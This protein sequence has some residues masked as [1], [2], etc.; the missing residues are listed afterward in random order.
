MAKR[1]LITQLPAVHQTDML[2]RFFGA[3]VDQVF[4][5]GRADPI[6]GYIGQRPA[7]TDTTKDFYVA[8]PDKNRA[9][10]QLEPTMVG[11]ENGAITRA[12]TYD[13]LLGYLATLGV[14]TTD[15]RRLFETD[16]YAW[17]PP[18]DI[19]KL[20]NPRQ[21]F[22]FGDVE[23]R[24]SLPV[25]PLTAP[26]AAAVANGIT[27]NFPLPSP[28]VGV[29]SDRNNPAV[30]VDGIQIEV[31]TFTDTHVTVRDVPPNGSILTIFRYAS[32]TEALTGLVTLGSAAL[33]GLSKIAP[34]AQ[35]NGTRTRFPLRAPL[36]T[37]PSPET[38]IA[39][40]NGIQ[41]S[42][43]DVLTAVVS[44]TNFLNGLSATSGIVDGSFIFDGSG[45][46]SALNFAVGDYVVPSGLTGAAAVNNGIEFR[47]TRLTGNTMVVSPAPDA[48]ATQITGWSLRSNA[49]VLAEAPPADIEVLAV[50]HAPFAPHVSRRMTQQRPALTSNMAV[51]VYDARNFFNGWDRAVLDGDTAYGGDTDD[52]F[53][54]EGVGISMR[55]VSFRDMLFGDTGAY[56]VVDRS[57]K[58]RNP[59]SVRNF[60]VHGDSFRWSGQTFP[61]RQAARPII[62]F[63]RDI[64]LWRYGS[65]RLDPA[66]AI[67]T[68]PGA[69]VLPL[70][71]F[72]TSRAIF[73]QSAW[74]DDTTTTVSVP[75]INGQIVGSVAVDGGRVLLEGQRLLVAQ[76]NPM[77]PSFNNSIYRVHVTEDVIDGYLENVYVLI[78]ESIQ[79]EADDILSIDLVEYLPFDADAYDTTYFDATER[80]V[81]FYFDGSRWERA[82][83]WLRR[84]DPL[85][86]L[87]DANGVALDNEAV[88][89]STTFVGNRLFGYATGSISDGV[90]DRSV[91][92][93][94]NNSLVFEVDSITQSIS[95]SNGEFTGTRFHA[96]REDGEDMLASNWHVRAKP[97]EQAF[98]SDGSYDVPV[99]L[100]ANPDNEEVTFIS[101]SGFF[102]H[103]GSLLAQQT[104]FV[105]ETYNN[106]NW[107]DLSR[108]LG[109]GQHILQH[110]A[111]LLRTML[112]ASDLRFDLPE[113][114]RYC[115][116]EYI[117]FRAKFLNRV[118]DLRD[119]HLV[120][121]ATN[122]TDM[123]LAG[124]SSVKTDRMPDG[125][126]AQSQMAVSGSFIPTTP[127][128]LGV[129]PLWMPKNTGNAIRGHDGSFVPLHGDYRDNALLGLELL[130]YNSI[131][132]IIR[133]SIRP[134]FDIDLYIDGGF[135]FSGNTGYSRSAF[136]KLL[137]PHFRRWCLVNGIDGV[138]NEG[139]L[140]A[141]PFTWNYRGISNWLGDALPGNWRAIYRWLFGTITPNETPWEMLGFNTRPVWWNEE[142]G[143]AP[144]TRG[145][146]T[147]WTD[148]EQGRIAQGPLAGIH[149]RY[150][151]IGML[152]VLPV[153]D[154][155]ALLDPVAAQIVRTPVTYQMA[156]RPWEPG[157]GGPVEEQWRATSEYGFSL[158]QIGFAMKPARFVEQ[159]WDVAHQGLVRGQWMN[160]TLNR[161]PRNSELLV[162]REQDANGDVV[163]IWGVQQWIVDMLASR[164]EAASLFG[165]AVRG[166]DA[167]LTHK[168][169]G[170]TSRDGLRV[171]TDS[172]G[173]V[174]DEDINIELYQSPSLRNEVYSGVIIERTERGWRVAG[175]DA[176]TPSFSI[177]PG[178]ENGP[179][180]YLGDTAQQQ[181][182][183]LWRAGV[184]YLTG[185]LVAYRES[186][187]RCNRSHT[188]ASTF[189]QQ[190]WTAEPGLSADQ[191]RV[192]LLTQGNNELRNIGYGSE[193][194]STADVVDFLV[195]YGRWL[196]ARG[197]LFN[198]VDPQSREVQDWTLAASEF[199]IWAR[200]SPTLGRTLALSP[201]SIGLKFNTARGTVVNVERATTGYFGLLDRSG[202]P[203]SARASQ[204]SRLD[205][206]I[207][208][209]ATNADIFCARLGIS[210]IE[211]LLVFAN[212]T[213]FN[214]LIFR[215]LFNLRQPRLKLIG[216]RS[217]EWAGRLD[218]S[219]FIV[220]DEQ[221]IPSFE[222]AAE[223][224]RT[225]FD[226]ELA[227]TGP[228]RDFA[229]HLIGYQDRD[230][231]RSLLVSDTTQ[232]EFYQGMIQQKGAPGV[233]SK[234]LRSQRIRQDRD[235]R[236]LE[237]WAFRAARFGV[238]SG[239]RF[240]I[241]MTQ[242]DIYSE[243][244]IIRFRTTPGAPLDWVEAPSGSRRWVV[245]PRSLENFFPVLNRR[246]PMALPTAGHV[247]LAEIDMPVFGFNELLDAITVLVEGGGIAAGYRFWV[248]DW[249]G[250][251]NIFRASAPVR[252]QILRVD[253]MI[254]PEEGSDFTRMRVQFNI[255]GAFT[256]ADIGSYVV[257]NNFTYSVPDMIGMRLIRDVAP[258]GKWVEL[259]EGGSS[260]YDFVEANV[261]GPEVMILRSVRFATMQ[262]FSKSKISH[263]TGEPIYIDTF[264]ISE[265]DQSLFGTRDYDT[266]IGFYGWAVVEM[267]NPTTSRIIRQ[268]PVLPDNTTIDHTE[269]YLRAS[270]IRANRLEVSPP[271]AS[272]LTVIDPHS[273]MIP[274]V[275]DKEIDFRLDYDPAAY[276]AEPL[277]GGDSW[278]EA[279]VGLVW[280]DLTTTRFLDPFTD[281]LGVDAERDHTEI[282][283]RAGNWC[284]IAPG[285][286]VDI[287]EWV[288]S[289]EPPS[290]WSRLSATDNLGLYSGTVYQAD[291][292][293]SVEAV[294]HDEA[295][296]RDVTYYYFWV[297]G[298]GRVRAEGIERRLPVSALAG[299]IAN[300]DSMD[301]P[302]LAAI[303]KD[304]MIVG[305]VRTLLDPSDTV[306]TLSLRSRIDDVEH[307]EWMLMRR[308]DERSLPPAW[309]WT[310]M[311]D[312]LVGFD[313]QMRALPDP[314]LHSDRA[315]G[316]GQGQNPFWASGG[317]GDIF[318][319]RSAFVTSVNRILARTPITK[320]RPGALE[321]LDKADTLARYLEWTMPDGEQTVE[322]P[323]R[324]EWT[325]EVFS[326]AERDQLL[327]QHGFL[328][329]IRAG[330]RPRILLNALSAPRPQW[331][332][333]NISDAAIQTINTVIG[334]LS[335]LTEAQLADQLFA[336]ADEIFVLA[337][338]YDIVVIDRAARDALVVNGAVSQDKRVLVN[339]DTQAAGLWTLWSYNPG[340]LVADE[341]GF[342]LIRT[343]KYRTSDFW[344]YADW[345]AD[346]Y[347]ALSAP[348][349][350]YA[351]AAERDLIEA[352]ALPPEADP[353]AR[354][355]MFRV[356][357]RS[358]RDAL[359]ASPTPPTTGQRVLVDEDN[360]LRG[361][362][363]LWRY[364]PTDADADTAGF[365][366]VRVQ[367]PP[368]PFVRLNDGGD[369]VWVWTAFEN[370]NWVIVGRERGTIEL[371]QSLADETRVAHGMN[372]AS[373]VTAANRDGSWELRVLFDSLLIS[374]V[375]T[376]L[377]LNEM[378]F[379]LIAHI[380]SK[381]DTVDW[382]FKTS[383]M[384]IAGYKEP[385]EQPPVKTVD[386][387]DNLLAYVDEVKPYHTK[388]R[389]FLRSLTPAQ[390]TA[391]VS[392]SD[393][394]K[395]IYIDPVLG[396][397]SLN[398]ND[399]ADAAILSTGRWKSWYDNY[400]VTDGPVRHVKIGM[401]FDRITD[402]GLAPLWDTSLLDGPTYDNGEPGAP[403]AV[404]RLRVTL[405]Y[406]GQQQSVL[407]LLNLRF[408]GTVIDGSTFSAGD[409][410]DVIA[411]GSNGNTSSTLLMNP[412]GP[413]NSYAL[414]DPYHEA[415][416]P[417]E[418]IVSAADDGLILINHTRATPG[419]PPQQAR[420]FLTSEM[421]GDTTF[422]FDHVAESSTA[423]AVYQDGVR[424][425]PGDVIFDH[426]AAEISL[427][428][429]IAETVTIFSAGPGG[430]A[431]VRET[432]HW[433][434]T[435]Q[436]SEFMLDG[437][438]GDGIVAVVID[439][440]RVPETGYTV[441]DASIVF[442]VPPTNGA[443]ITVIVYDYGDITRVMVES[444]DPESGPEW[445]LAYPDQVTIPEHAGTVVEVN[446]LR[447]IP[448]RSYYFTYDGGMPV[449]RL[450]FAPQMT[451]PIT[452]HVGGLPYSSNIPRI[453]RVTTEYFDNDIW[454][455]NQYDDALDITDPDFL[456]RLEA[457]I[458]SQPIQNFADNRLGFDQFLWDEEVIDVGVA[459]GQFVL[460][461]SYLVALDATFV[462]T[463]VIF[464]VYESHDYS[465][466]GGKLHILGTV[467]TTDRIEVT[468]LSN[469]GIC[470]LR[471]HVFEAERDNSYRLSALPQYA[472]YSW[473]TVAGRRL[474]PTVEFDFQEIAIGLDD[475]PWDQERI[476]QEMVQLVTVPREA[477]TVVATVML[478][479]PARE[480]MSFRVATATTAIDRMRISGETYREPVWDQVSFDT[481]EFDRV[482]PTPVQLYYMDAG[483]WDRT[484]YRPLF[485]GR[486]VQDLGA[487]GHTITINLRP[488]PLLSRKAAP[489][490]SLAIPDPEAQKPGVVW[491][492]SERIEYYAM[493]INGDIAT[494]GE[495][496]RGTLGTSVSA[497]VRT[498]RH[499]V[500][501]GTR[502][503]FAVAKEGTAYVM[504][505]GRVL[506]RVADY[507]V[508]SAAGVTTV[509]L[510][511][512]PSVGERVV[513]AIQNGHRH[514]AGSLA[515]NGNETYLP[516]V[517]IGAVAGDRLRMPMKTIIAG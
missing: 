148:I 182:I 428:S 199:V 310:N 215:P 251:W 451:S 192:P 130:I 70:G 91:K 431:V 303:A 396:Y 31:V 32:L 170:F 497:E 435:G 48:F 473:V 507:T 201:G 335:G 238:P 494:L 407:E 230:Y 154:T 271:I 59:W 302:W 202:K 212:T 290:Q 403:S 261:V 485:G 40:V 442:D 224:V 311:R 278:G 363:S 427:P 336:A 95:W 17:A 72:D 206:E 7:Y 367:S 352:E 243:P 136:T 6:S 129:A 430:D 306:I 486:L 387:T 119:R 140:H 467:G 49:L 163:V 79:P 149:A 102:A 111:P 210:Q 58:D 436:V 343:Q 14:D 376:G 35:G 244:Q 315:G 208:I 18:V 457:L 379:D 219:G 229:R 299:M 139:Y 27:N 233:F 116:R 316:I 231:L 28:I 143:P 236:F 159:A 195:G 357:D 294:V 106:N 33:D 449:R 235:L 88:F 351:D 503:V 13:D 337:K 15:P 319:A 345:Y 394:D 371:S 381:Q 318:V 42:V 361:F 270:R 300:P 455:I 298:L 213:I 127:A 350:I 69:T 53:F 65:R 193:L 245:E 118:I 423:V 198:T 276:V 85:F 301:Q 145:N 480:A 413:T 456:V 242:E 324:D 289:T 464:T 372:E 333:W 445:T 47:I 508:V 344:S 20:S 417:E 268:Q 418:R 305:G 10:Y 115:E 167:R 144:Y 493:Q 128:A 390:D 465:V 97:I 190:Y 322:P 104:G 254:A 260:G 388:V 437:G 404:D 117:R 414:A 76:S 332:I 194:V 247:R 169:G 71:A 498:V 99:G 426:H 359:L 461:D 186:V 273:G 151:R 354:D 459:P 120:T 207:V 458:Q 478:G 188:S 373:L 364:D 113:A 347:S 66:Q 496:R 78:P 141:D 30:F 191:F 131:P 402:V 385:L 340:S 492:G 237:E 470:R 86:A 221:I 395:P 401:L 114:I 484:R 228:M 1:R 383:L 256:T 382:A 124:I 46:L 433:I 94:E 293:R 517:P 203:I 368:H 223:D 452:L 82:Q 416:R 408:R 339:V 29:A 275:V 439:G 179:R 100:Q 448:P 21:Y 90:L 189:E 180:T 454:D 227:D 176:R 462:S 280:W 55:F 23:G 205:G 185:M 501:D 172:F 377:E 325:I 56:V 469:P 509:S 341:F 338:A 44:P 326:P 161:R 386:E 239:P 37:P 440:S 346:G 510:K 491:I 314:R 36:Y 264:G 222:K 514:V 389:E 453:E 288:R 171:L 168:M 132:E 3:T 263:L 398:P 406:G 16:S 291:N 355:H 495:L 353:L 211:H 274:G 109:K 39:L 392:V 248:Y 75:D 304:T 375:M 420:Q 466:I 424:T 460:Y 317:R 34:F 370:G 234:L 450:P 342:V 153:D 183:N 147:L 246:P 204:I 489:A 26:F 477:G 446:G 362:W 323:P 331:S 125:P 107:R 499:F 122:D 226:I 409:D 218:A 502:T 487:G 393:F 105:G 19:D 441:G 327:G 50:R 380:H 62:E 96:I 405:P 488:D 282:V 415:N 52:R 232:F 217:R 209:A 121:D 253:Q 400:R 4:Q 397:R 443:S 283:H 516:D 512:A 51:V 74:D 472:E 309:L 378:F 178:D 463:D 68:S 369:G 134:Q 438:V 399:P 77:E 93:D 22:W 24:D 156:T 374:G 297:R 277:G 292:P 162:H 287:Y 101:R 366:L 329:S 348:I 474:A 432:H 146:L 155:G 12:L 240:D 87:Y 349:V 225:M 504:V 135:Y 25:L 45:D 285:A 142:Y 187:Y 444:L 57:S 112:T 157:D 196:E 295:L 110:R 356:T 269:L 365:V 61:T 429:L 257:F 108:D 89:P 511:V 84:A 262:E 175:Y 358:A 312:G 41:V 250:D 281:E 98:R 419:M 412:D 506:H 200:S 513:V 126:F 166:L 384:T 220:L 505:G 177:I 475:F 173:L 515:T 137:A 9:A 63:T 241:S 160:T 133:S 184:F 2:R 258:D 5:P 267:S 296:A 83:Q 214:D 483:A 249:Q 307:T 320:D 92:R 422:K 138:S 425:A 103:F 490:L 447:L 165:N 81:E 216:K 434:Q 11:V 60:W 308:K 313:D 330:A 328:A 73:D 500:G 158:A 321:E 391:S 123:A 279:Q 468:T 411:D 272:N 286:S 38:P 252:N 150:K 54:I 80:E 334:P 421:G 482:P 181:A 266:G 197:W 481:D 471:T 8:E 265:W 410:P 174:P 259:E 67:L 64:K 360:I 43:S 476:E 164:G 284:R 479:K 152:A 255:D